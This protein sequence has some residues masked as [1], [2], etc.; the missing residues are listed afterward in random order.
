MRPRKNAGLETIQ[1]LRS[2][3]PDDRPE[4][5]RA[6]LDFWPTVIDKP[7]FIY[8]IQDE[9]GPVKIGLA[10]KPWT[11]LGELQVGNPRDLELK[12]VIL[13][14]VETEEMLH[15]HWAPASHVR[16]EWF[17]NGYETAILALAA[18]TSARQIADY[19]AGEPLHWIAN[20]RVYWIHHGEGAAA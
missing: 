8:F 3:W 15:S 9:S 11:R 16:G 18:E 14:S 2:A 10:L 12:A 6:P 19:K 5:V 17:G 1:E 13:G 20:S 7:L 4:A